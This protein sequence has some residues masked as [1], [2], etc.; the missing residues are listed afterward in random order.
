MNKLRAREVFTPAAKPS[1]TYINREHLNLEFKLLDALETTGVIVSVT[2]PSKSGKTVLCESVVGTR[3]LFLITGGGIQSERDFWARIRSKLSLPAQ[4]STS[5]GTSSGAKLETEAKGG[6]SLPMVFDAKGGVTSGVDSHSSNSTTYTSGVDDGIQLLGY[7]QKQGV[8]LVVD[9]FHYI[10]ASTRM[11]LAQQF[12]EAARSGLAIAVISV[13]HRSD[14]AIRANPDLRG[15]VATVDIP[16]WT[17]DEL[18]A[19]AD[20]GFP[21]LNMQPNS[22]V[23]ERMVIE[24]IK[25][26]QLMQ[27]LC[28][29]F[30][31]Q[32]HSDENLKELTLFDLSSDELGLL[33]RDASTLT[34]CRSAYEVL[35]TG[36][37]VR[38][39]ERKEY[40]FGDGRKGDVYEVIL[41]ALSN[42]D[43]LLTIGYDTLKDRIANVCVGEVPRGVSIT[44]ALEQMNKAVAEKLQNDRVL[45]WNDNYIN[46]PDPYFLYYLR[47]A[48]L[49]E[50]G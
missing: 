31:R 34:N 39:Q 49:P 14:D 25:S 9:D 38:G 40:S 44:E 33:L 19:I 22:S 24:S 28:L 47:W 42:G 3:G 21:K 20:V 8:T 45:E 10:P 1:H 23:I 46:L 48:E 35:V 7:L 37:R 41:R 4:I 27:A 6:V 50:L 13:T 12:K 11:S 29:Q 5:V 18:R 36:P 30:C 26:P 17:P 15:R 16:Y 43:P 2:G 32:V